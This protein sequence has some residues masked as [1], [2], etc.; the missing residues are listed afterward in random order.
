MNNR[1]IECASRAGATSRVH[2]R[3]EG[4]D[5]SAG[6][7][8]SVWRATPSQRLRQ[9]SLCQLHDEEL[10]QAFMDMANAE[11]KKS[12]AVKAETKLRE[13]AIPSQ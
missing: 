10:D 4:H 9:S 5:G 3:R 11:K 7:G 13:V 2:E 12:A 6:L 1:V 8:G